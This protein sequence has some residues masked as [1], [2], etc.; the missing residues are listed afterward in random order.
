MALADKGARVA[1]GSRRTPITTA[2]MTMT[3]PRPEWGRP[4]G[5]GGS[6]GG[7]SADPLPLAGAALIFVGVVVPEWSRSGPVDVRGGDAADAGRGEGSARVHCRHR[8]AHRDD[9]STAS[10]KC[11][12]GCG[13]RPLSFPAGSTTTARSRESECLCRS[14][15]SCAKPANARARSKDPPRRGPVTRGQGGCDPPGGRVRRRRGGS[16]LDGHA[17]VAQWQRR[18]FVIVR[19][20]VRLPPPALSRDGSPSPLRRREDGQR[21]SLDGVGPVTGDHRRSP[22]RRRRRGRWPGP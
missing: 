3:R 10:V 11:R 1:E 20:W 12:C 2:T 18:R 8:R 15:P 13:W 21:E 19:S 9:D 7:R 17:G 4:D 6:P 14:M 5:S 16:S 22:V